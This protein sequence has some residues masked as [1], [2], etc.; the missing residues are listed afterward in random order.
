MAHRTPILRKNTLY[1]Q[2]EGQ[3]QTITVG[4]PDW[5]TW[6]KTASTFAFSSEHGSFTAH[7]EQPGTGAVES[8]GK[9]TACSGESYVVPTWVSRR[10]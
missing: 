4:T 1:F 2:Q 6:L 7:K 5:Y 10:R 9:H 3:Q 8:T